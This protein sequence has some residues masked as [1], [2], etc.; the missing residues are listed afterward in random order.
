MKPVMERGIRRMHIS[1]IG[2]DLGTAS[3]LVYVRG[4]GVVLEEPSVVA[5]DKDT[6]EIQAIGEEARQMLGRTP[7]N[8][9]A[10]RPL[11]Q[12]V[13]SDYA[14]TEK[15]LKYFIQ[16]ALGKRMLKRPIVS[17]CTPGGATQVERR[18]LVDAVYGAGARDVVVI[19]EPIAGALGSGIDISQ[20]VGSMVV[21]IGGGTTEI[22]VIAMN[23]TVV[24]ASVRVAGDD[25]DEALI[26]YI[27]KT[28]SMLIGSSSA[29]AVKKAAGC[30]YERPE[31][32]KVEIR[33][34][35]ILTGLPMV[36]CLSSKEAL[37]ALKAP[38]QAIIAGIH[39]VLE[40]TPPELA[41]DIAERGILLTGGGSLIYGM[42]KLIEVSTGIPVRPAED[43][44]AAAAVGTGQYMEFMEK[45][46][47]HRSRYGRK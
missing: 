20:P 46:K 21:D 40:K 7:K 17:I 16:K 12:G 34:R 43:P 11:R 9:A 26:H 2:I 1:D 47:S 37:Q 22:A 29:E 35:N 31:E 4:K 45:S 6:N 33:G 27:H 18:A 30:V 3:V 24:S 13:V 38:A 10:V 15:M 14:V 39:R 36:I 44:V 32:E 42:D 28:Y 8:I 23:D 19:P 41:S 5:Y 25:F